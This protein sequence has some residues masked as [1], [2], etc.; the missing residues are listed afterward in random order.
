MMALREFIDED[1]RDW[2]AWDTTPT[3]TQVRREFAGGWLTFESEREKRRVAP[4]PEDWERMPVE[5]LRLLL[6]TATA[7]TPGGP[8]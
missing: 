7:N 5:Q 4:V 8:S 6:R 3:S 2:C 1:G